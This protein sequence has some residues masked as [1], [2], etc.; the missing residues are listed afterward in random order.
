MYAFCL[1]IE[2][3]NKKNEAVGTAGEPYFYH[4]VLTKN[5]AYL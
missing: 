1:H 3:C 5:R 2:T 4:I